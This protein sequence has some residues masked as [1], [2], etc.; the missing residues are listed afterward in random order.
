MTTAARPIEQKNAHWYAPDATPCYEIIGKTTGRPRP[1]NIKDAREQG[2]V[3]SVT[4]ILQLLA[5]P[6]LESWKQEMIVLAI[7]TTPQKPGEPIDEFVRRVVQVEKQ[8]DQIGAQAR[9]LG[10]KI[11]DAI[12][13]ALNEMSTPDDTDIYVEPVLAECAKLGKV[14]WTEKIMVGNGYA[15]RWDACFGQG[16]LKTIVDFKTSGTIPKKSYTEHRMQ[17]A[18]AAAILGSLTTRTMNIYISTKEPGK[19]VAIE[20]PPWLP[21]FEAFEHLVKLWQYINGF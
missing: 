20:N 13:F 14:L 5:K 11:H 9:E 12:E 16:R 10:T 7:A 3:P 21:D 4:S 2:L 19:V 6:G 17:L 8:Q 18:A 1:V 15:G